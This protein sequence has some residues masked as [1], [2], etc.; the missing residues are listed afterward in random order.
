MC[1]CCGRVALMTLIKT[2]SFFTDIKKYIDKGTGGVPNNMSGN[3][4]GSGLL[5]IYIQAVIQSLFLESGRIPL[6][7]SDL[8]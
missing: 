6:S 2:C 8:H 7:S 3:A 4:H 1:S 5:G